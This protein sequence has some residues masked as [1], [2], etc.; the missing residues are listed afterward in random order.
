[1]SEPNPMARSL[2]R[3]L[4]LVQWL[5]DRNPVVRDMSDPAGY[6]VGTYRTRRDLGYIPPVD[7]FDIEQL[8][9]A[10]GR[11][12]TLDATDKDER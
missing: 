6:A 10:M 7:L 4:A 1:M 5:E 3:V 2:G 8:A 11:I 9:R 12:I